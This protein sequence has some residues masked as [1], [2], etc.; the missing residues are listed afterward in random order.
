MQSAPMS[1]LPRL[2]LLSLLALVAVHLTH[3][4]EP[5]AYQLAKAGNRYVGEQS[6]DKIKLNRPNDMVEIGDVYIS[7]SN[8]EVERADLHV[9]RVN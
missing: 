6:K 2:V 1:F 7:A 4:G 9:E 8:G 5:T 3:A